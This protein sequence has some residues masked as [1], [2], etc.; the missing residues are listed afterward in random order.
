VYST[1]VVGDG[2]WHH[3]VG[4]NDG[5]YSRLYVDGYETG[6]AKTSSGVATTQDMLCIGNWAYVYSS[7]RYLNGSVSNFKV[8]NRALSATEILT[9]YFSTKN[10]FFPNENIVRNGL[11]LNVDASKSNSYSGIGNTIYDLSGSGNTGFLTGGP[12]FSGLNAG[13][14]VFDGSNDYIDI[15]SITSITGNFTVAVWFFTTATTD[16]NFKRLVDLN[17][18]TGFWLGRQTNTN[19]WGGGI[20]ESNEPY[21]IYLPFTNGQWHYLVSI[22]SGSTH[23]LYGDGVSNTISNTVSTGNLSA[24]SLLIA[25]QPEGGGTFL[26][27]NISQVQL[28]NRALSATEVM[29]NFNAM[30]ERYNI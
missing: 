16:A 25:K 21:G 24:S 14:I 30:R 27:G 18:A 1:Q 9:D 17:Y 15:P 3:I 11:V 23:I 8:Y 28:Y 20:I 22:R 10:R 2:G 5:T 29:Q 6:T 13:S 4:T 12:T 7:A 26:N 19:N